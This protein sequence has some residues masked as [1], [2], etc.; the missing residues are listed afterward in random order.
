MVS[1]PLSAKSKGKA[2]ANTI[3]ASFYNAWKNV[4]DKRS[5]NTEH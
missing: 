3:L 4:R 1:D 5:K 2:R